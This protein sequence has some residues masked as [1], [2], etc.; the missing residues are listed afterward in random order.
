M[1]DNNPGV[2]KKHAKW[3][4]LAFVLLVLAFAAVMFTPFTVPCVFRL[5]TTIPC[6][7]C[8]L[9][10]A[11]L[12]LARFEF[13]AALRMNLLLVPLT[14]FGAVYLACA[15][16]ELRGKP[17]FARLNKALSKKWVIALAAVLMTV[18]WAYNIAR[19]I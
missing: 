5:V 14:M 13:L 3:V 17:A 2:N 4:L 15:V 19:G 11:Y 16:L 12:H 10:R 9:S 7:A 6:P 1:V 8:G 18:S